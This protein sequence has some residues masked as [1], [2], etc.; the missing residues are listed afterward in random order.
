MIIEKV[1]YL[2]IVIDNF[3]SGECI[4]EAI[5]Q[6]V[7]NRLKFLYRQARFLD[8][9]CKKTLCSGLI[10]CHEKMAASSKT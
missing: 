7:N 6:K 2:G 10:Q 9:F 8:T 1:E 5:V 3:L 4:V